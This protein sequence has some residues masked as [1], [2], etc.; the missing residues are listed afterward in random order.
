MKQH[1]GAIKS[2]ASLYCAVQL[3]GLIIHGAIEK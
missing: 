2:L 3:K 1:K